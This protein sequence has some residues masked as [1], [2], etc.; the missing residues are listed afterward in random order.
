MNAMSRRSLAKYAADGLSRGQS[1]IK[2]AKELASALVNAGKQSE[3]ELLAG[4][5][6]YELE[7]RG[8]LAVATVTSASTLSPSL[9]TQLSGAIKKLAGVQEVDLRTRVDKSVIGVVR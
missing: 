1:P 6:A 3:A 8:L 4:D 7:N 2:L 5:I 9:R